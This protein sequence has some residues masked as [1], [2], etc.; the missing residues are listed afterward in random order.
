MNKATALKAISM[1][2]LVAFSL[3]TPLSP[4]L[5]SGTSRV[6][7]TPLSY[8]T[9]SLRPSRDGNYQ[10]WVPHPLTLSGWECLD[11]DTQNGDSDYVHTTL[12]GKQCL[13]GLG[14]ASMVANILN[15]KVVVYAKCATTVT[16]DLILLVVVCGNFPFQGN[17]V[18]LTDSYS[19]YESSWAKNPKT[20]RSWTWSDFDTLQAGFES[21]KVFALP[22]DWS[23]TQ[24]Y[25]EITYTTSQD[26]DGKYEVLVEWINKYPDADD[27]S[28]CDDSAEGLMNKLSSKGWS[29]REYGNSRVWESDFHENQ[30]KYVDDV[31]LAFFS[32]HGSSSWDWTYWKTLHSLY[33]STDHDDKNLVPG[34]VKGLWGNKDLEWI[35]FDACQ[36]LADD[37]GGYW[38][39]TMDGLHLI[40]GFKTIAYDCNTGYWWADGMVSDG[41]QDPPMRVSDAWC[42]AARKTQSGNGVVTRVIGEDKESLK[43]LLWGEGDVSPDFYPDDTYYYTDQKISDTS[44]IQISTPFPNRMNLYRVVLP[45][46]D[47]P[48]VKS[49]G[50][51]FGLAGDVGYYGDGLYYM[52]DGTKYL[53]VSSTGSILYGDSSELWVIRETDPQLPTKEQSEYIAQKFL[54]DSNLL[55]GD[56]LLYDTYSSEQGCVNKTDGTLI[57]STIMDRQVVFNRTIDGYSVVGPGAKLQVF[58]G[59][60]N[61]TIGFFRVFRPKAYAGT[62]DIMSE[63]EAIDNLTAYGPKI[64]LGGAPNGP[65]D[66]MN[67]IST[68]L[69]YYEAGFNDTQEELIPCYVFLANFMLG[70]QVSFTQ[71]VYIPAASEFMPPIAEIVSPSD[72]YACSEGCVVSFSGQCAA[73]GTPPLSYTWHSDIDGYLGQG[74]TLSTSTLS[75]GQKE[76]VIIP[77]TI[78][79]TV[80]DSTGN[81]SSAYINVTVNPPPSVSI[82][83]SSVIMDLGQSE[84]FTSTMANGTLP[85]SYKWCLDGAPV[86]GATSNTWT[87]TPT[88]TGTHTVYLNAT[89][90]SE[91]EAKSNT[92]PVTVNS[93]LQVSI[94]P[95]STAIYLGQSVG[96]TSSVSGGT[97]PYALQ[98]Y[99]DSVAV[100]QA[101]GPT[102]TFTPASTGSYSIHLHVT[103]DA[104]AA[105]DSSSASVTVS[106]PPPSV[107]G[108]E[109]PIDKFALVAPYA[110]TLILLAVAIVTSIFVKRVKRKG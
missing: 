99:K 8:S 30:Q 23:V 31:D 77:H 1:V 11:E 18:S 67:I 17:T 106:A 83:P 41:C 12:D 20:G 6:Q 66:S 19:K 70:G 73:F 104:G 59:E 60:N 37:H 3:S 97:S 40:L 76:E 92:V 78:T 103:D 4:T 84:T 86:S 46:I 13:C 49:I 89:D 71:Y 39:S 80:T 26:E 51:I 65:W 74:Q 100:P 42:W 82:D 90:S 15:V 56:A 85:Y 45:T 34:E 2:L 109:I 48:Y 24:L 94:S 44:A 50:S 47:I 110:V 102:W 53:Q 7:T 14:H 22:T 28:Q 88:L 33:F 10:E 101:T 93:G 58:L 62:V 43:D 72:G 54:S 79:L 95:L 55:P 36:V 64:M 105:L 35:A 75:V 61:R 63:Q 81:S 29:T 16:G 32:G 38:A 68:T 87:F 9:L 91:I 107:G 52:T 98:W 27:L 21:K 108:E 96:F 69:G 5:S 57:N 25:V